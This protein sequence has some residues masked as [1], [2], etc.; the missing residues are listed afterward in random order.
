MKIGLYLAY[1]IH[2]GASQSK[3][4]LGRYWVMLAKTMMQRGHQISI[5]TLPWAKPLILAQLEDN[6]CPLDQVEFICPDKAPAMWRVLG[7][8][9][10]ER[11]KSLGSGIFALMGFVLRTIDNAMDLLARI[12]NLFLFL[13][14]SVLFL[15]VG[16]LLLPLA[17]L[18]V[19]AVLLAFLMLRLVGMDVRTRGG[20]KKLGKV[21]RG[22]FSW[23]TR[24]SY[25]LLGGA[26]S[27]HGAE[28]IRAVSA[29]DLQARVE[30]MENPVDIWYCPMAY[31]P[32]F[33]RLPGVKS[34]CFPDLV[35]TIFPYGFA[36]AGNGQAFQMTQQV[37]QTVRKG[38]YFVVYSQYQKDA[39]LVNQ[40]GKD[41]ENIAAIDLFANETKDDLLQT[42]RGE[43]A[44]RAWVQK[45]AR[46]A[47]STLFVHELSPNTH[48]LS[49]PLKYFTPESLQYVFYASQ[50]RASK[51]V[52]NLVKAYHLLQR[53]KEVPYKLVLTGH[54]AHDAT[55]AAYVEKHGLASDV[56]TFPSVSNRQLSALYACAELSV[57]PTLFEGGFPMTFYE[58]M[59]VGTPA[60]LSR[61]PQV[62]EAVSGYGLEDCLFDPFDP[63]D[64]ARKIDYGVQHRSELSG[65]Q[66][67]LYQA[68]QEQTLSQLGLAYEQAF[69][70]FVRTE[71]GEE[72]FAG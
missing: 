8:F 27:P 29:A 59:S 68:L 56:L 9:R 63:E 51:N 22:V 42:V 13:L 61:I 64:I 2:R 40:L 10:K 18:F 7:R 65:R 41:P 3:E 47:L 31:W 4:G 66:E 71:K 49:G 25:S 44:P 12:H 48:Y 70:Q 37:R 60:I 15:A 52:L 53:E 36:K 32:E 34:L 55:L 50:F 6:D 26:L 11:E 30:D 17:A 57:T 1:E 20:R 67:K 58:G 54:F 23:P 21:L 72:A 69:T 43:K 28:S 24:L 5:A 35:T 19:V 45:D 38:K 46:E 14:V 39:I 33:H 62:L 16:I